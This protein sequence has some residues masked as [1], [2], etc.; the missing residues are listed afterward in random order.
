MIY[1][2]LYRPQ[3][4]CGRGNVFTRV[5]HSVHRG[6]CLSA[7]WDNTPLR[8][9][10]PPGAGTPPEQAPP[11]RPTP[12]GKIEGIRS[13]PTPKREIEGDQIQAHT[14]GGNWGGSDPGPHPRGNWGGSNPGPHPRG[15]LRRIKSRPTPKGEIEGDQIQPL[16]EANSGIRSMSSWYASYWNAFLF[17]YIFTT[18]KWSL[19]RLCFYTCLSVIL[20]MGG[21]HGCEEGVHGREGA[22]V[23]AWGACVVVGG[24]AWLW[25]AC[26]VAGGG[27]WDMMR[28]G[29]WVGSMHPTGMHSCLK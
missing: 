6:V 5:C 29:Q 24:H 14:Q 18:H 4:S 27:A 15:K 17:L 23:V 19:W 2:C 10:H 20:F 26:M 9:R 12:K 21:M 7:C 28:Y 8:S 1:K 16:W 22:C 13:R 3:R 25:G 11:S